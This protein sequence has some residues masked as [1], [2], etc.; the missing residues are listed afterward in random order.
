MQI[1]LKYGQKSTIN[2]PHPGPYE[3]QLKV[4][5]SM[6]SKNSS[7]LHVPLPV[8]YKCMIPAKTLFHE[9]WP[10]GY[11]TFFMLNSAEHKISTAL[12]N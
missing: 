2:I 12:K 4:W 10:G 5:P 3:M 9:T 8:T 1:D 6:G 7:A 11:K